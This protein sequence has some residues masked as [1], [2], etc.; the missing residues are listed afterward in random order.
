M[1]Q[2]IRYPP[3]RRLLGSSGSE[4]DPWATDSTIGY[5]T[6]P[7]AVLLGNAGAIAASVRTRLY[8]SPSEDRPNRPTMNKLIRRPNP[9]LTTACATRKAI[10]T[11]NT[12]VFAN[13]ANAL[14]GE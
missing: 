3:S 1:E 9:H 4:P 13:P 2:N 12:L 10:T 5:S 6:P 14:D 7:R 11:S 8:A